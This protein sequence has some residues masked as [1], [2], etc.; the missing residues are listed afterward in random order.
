MLHHGHNHA[1]PRTPLE[2]PCTFRRTLVRTR[3][4]KTYRGRSS[5]TARGRL[6][7][8]DMPPPRTMAS[9]SSTLIRDA[10]DRASRSSY[11]LRAA[12]A[13]VP[14]LAAALTISGPVF[15]LPLRTL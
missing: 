4:E 6:G 12:I 7:R 1:A 8:L 13:W 3:S 9:G 10:S 11:L 14:P 2:S 5:A 15:R